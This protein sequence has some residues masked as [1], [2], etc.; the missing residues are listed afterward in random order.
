MWKRFLRAFAITGAA[1]LALTLAL[2]LLVDPLGVSPVAMIEPKPGYAM[3]DRRFVAQQLIRSGQF[4]SFL[5]GSSTIHS[6]DPD[7]AEAAFG[8]AFANLAIHGATPHELARVLEAIGRNEPHLRTLVLGLDSGRWCSAKA[9]GTYHPKAVFPESLYDADRLDD[10]AALLNLEMLDTSLDQLAIDLKIAAPETEADGY[11]NE[12]DDAKWKPFKPDKD[13]CKL[14]CDEKA[15]ATGGAEAH[16][17][18]PDR[19]FP[20]LKLLEKA[21]ASLPAETKLIVAVMPPHVSTQP[22]NANERAD[23]DLCKRRI[24][25]IAT[26]SHGY[27]IDFDGRDRHLPRFGRE[28]RQ[29]QGEVQAS[30]PA[31]LGRGRQGLP[32]LR[33]VGGEEHV[34]QEI[35]GHRA[36]DLPHRRQRRD[37]QGL[38]KGEGPRPCRG[39]AGG[40]LL[41]KIAMAPSTRRSSVSGQ[42]TAGG[43]L[44]LTKWS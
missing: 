37:P 8:G 42:N 28:P 34:W 15:A 20:A 33:R 38:A 24:A 43:N 17:A 27:A 13:G 35:Y 12:L 30:L 14:A 18:Q 41:G 23:H 4:D 7:W 32:S 22:N 36:L 2:I 39:G 44:T 19:P 3:K 29:V 1:A 6:V 26:H 5:V 11:R 40:C 9:S 25:A 16:P 31:R 10:F 21:L